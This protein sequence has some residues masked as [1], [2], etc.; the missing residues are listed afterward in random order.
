[1]NLSKQSADGEKVNMKNKPTENGKII[2]RKTANEQND[3]RN[4]K[5][6]NLSKQIS[7]RRKVTWKNE[8]TEN[9]SRGK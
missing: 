4:A 5:S 8:H 6:K 7:L 9:M 3:F 1:M 2:L